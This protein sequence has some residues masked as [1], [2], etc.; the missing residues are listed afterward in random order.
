MDD[1]PKVTKSPNFA[2]DSVVGMRRLNEMVQKRIMNNRN[3]QI[4][5]PNR[6]NLG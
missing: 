4:D 5:L 1:T 2:A 6:L 3:Q